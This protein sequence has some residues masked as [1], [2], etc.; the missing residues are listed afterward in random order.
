MVIIQGRKTH[1]YK[2]GEKDVRRLMMSPDELCHL[3]QQ[4]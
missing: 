2:V 3:V 4:A 1:N